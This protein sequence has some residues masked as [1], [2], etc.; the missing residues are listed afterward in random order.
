MQP[1]RA[2]LR[3]SASKV[4][5]GPA[6]PETP[7]TGPTLPS[8][9]VQPVGVRRRSNAPY[10]VDLHFWW[11]RWRMLGC[12][13]GRFGCGKC[14]LAEFCSD[15]SADRK[16]WDY[17]SSGPKKAIMSLWF[18]WRRG[19]HVFCA[20][21][22]TN[23]KNI[24]LDFFSKAPERYHICVHT[25]IDMNMIIYSY[26]YQQFPSLQAKG[27]FF[28]TET[29]W[30]Q[31]K[32]ALPSLKTA[33]WWKST[34]T[35]LA[36]PWMLQLQLGDIEIF[37]VSLFLIQAIFGIQSKKTLLLLRHLPQN[38]LQR[39]ELAILVYQLQATLCRRKV[40]KVILPRRWIQV[41]E[42]VS[43]EAVVD[44]RW[45]RRWGLKERGGWYF[46][47]GWFFCDIR[48]CI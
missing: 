44:P 28:C 26:T 30:W 40:R 46:F 5:G 8:V 25:Y 32:K 4:S 42:Q 31:R 20:H 37:E 39:W 18:V 43:L 17:L 15:A 11:Y 14:Y 24:L 33:R 27:H 21:E 6:P 2:L 16:L 48:R 7:V 23:S 10:V 3:P 13:D 29:S 22:F 41:H 45:R 9:E 34:L 19:L 35:L 47:C 12:N 38:Q 36:T 1:L